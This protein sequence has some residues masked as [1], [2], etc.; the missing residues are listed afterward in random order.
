MHLI[1]CDVTVA[2]G[3]LI[4]VILCNELDIPT[5]GTRDCQAGPIVLTVILYTM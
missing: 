4:A 1:K 3:I 5:P 2:T